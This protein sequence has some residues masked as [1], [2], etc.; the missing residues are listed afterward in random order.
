VNDS[1]AVAWELATEAAQE[2]GALGVAA[3]V[4]N[5]VSVRPIAE[6]LLEVAGQID[7]GLIVMG[8][9][10][11]SRLRNLFR[12]SVMQQLVEKTTIPLFLAH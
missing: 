8:A 3:E 9:F 6:A 4:H 2:L 11:H 5:V 10:A 1:G 12:G 7:A